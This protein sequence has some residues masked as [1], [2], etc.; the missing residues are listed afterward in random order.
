MAGKPAHA[1]K[2]WGLGATPPLTRQ[3]QLFFFDN[4]KLLL[5]Y[6]DAAHSIFVMIG[7]ISAKHIYVSNTITIFGIQV[8]RQDQLFFFFSN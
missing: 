6:Y 3:F 7:E 5:N 8:N 2:L 1:S 4:K